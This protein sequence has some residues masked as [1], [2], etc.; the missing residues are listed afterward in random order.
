MSQIHRQIFRCRNDTWMTSWCSLYPSSHG[1][2]GESG[3]RWT[4]NDVSLN[5]NNGWHLDY[6]VLQIL[7][8][9]DRGGKLQAANGKGL[10]WV[11]SYSV[12]VLDTQSPIRSHV[13]VCVCLTIHPCVE[14]W[15]LVLD[16]EI[17]PVFL[18]NYFSPIFATE[19]ASGVYQTHA[20][21]TRAERC[22]GSN[23]QIF[24]LGHILNRQ[25]QISSWWLMCHKQ[26]GTN[27]TTSQ[28]LPETLDRSHSKGLNVAAAFPIVF[29]N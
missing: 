4:K 15:V 18:H 25:L 12:Y 5:Y 23:G 29:S 16:K 21:R 19:L 7:Q 24:C 14:W 28:L 10:Y 1:P 17:V 22:R 20:Q 9:W 8:G 3:R 27:L 2:W 13:C 26:S 6:M 11:S